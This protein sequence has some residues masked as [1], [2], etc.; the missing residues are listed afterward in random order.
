MQPRMR[1]CGLTNAPGQAGFLEQIGMTTMHDSQRA[2][3]ILVLGNL[4]E[5]TANSALSRLRSRTHLTEAERRFVEA[6]Q[7]EHTLHPPQW[8]REE[9]TQVGAAEN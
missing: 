8:C 4:C 1:R 5:A 6:A 9:V 3:A 7:R 2:A